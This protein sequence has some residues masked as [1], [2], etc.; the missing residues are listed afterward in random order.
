MDSNIT[1]VATL[2][3]P[4][5]EVRGHEIDEYC[6]SRGLELAA[7]MGII[8]PGAQKLCYEAVRDGFDFGVDWQKREAA[9]RG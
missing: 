3:G 6:W 4:P 1:P 9:K 2:T 5:P 7:K 8:E